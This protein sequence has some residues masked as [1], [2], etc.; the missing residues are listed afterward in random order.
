MRQGLQW[1]RPAAKA[2][3]EQA[4]ESDKGATYWPWRNTAFG[5]GTKTESLTCR[6]AYWNYYDLRSS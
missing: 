4:G 1:Q 6:P 2:D 5:A 3:V